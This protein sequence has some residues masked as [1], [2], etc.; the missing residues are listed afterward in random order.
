[1]PCSVSPGSDLGEQ[2]LEGP[3]LQLLLFNTRLVNNKAP[4]IYDLI[5]EEGVNLACI[6]W[7]GPEGGVPFSEMCPAR[8]Q[9]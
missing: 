8:F 9:V 2:I 1:M 6:T 4:I 5:T 3:G 7:L